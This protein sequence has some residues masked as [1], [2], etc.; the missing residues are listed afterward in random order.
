MQ[1]ETDFNPA[2]GQRDG[3]DRL[4]K[5]SM[6]G[7]VPDIRREPDGHNPLY[8]I[9][10]ARE[11]AIVDSLVTKYMRGV[12]QQAFG[13]Y[14]FTDDGAPPTTIDAPISDFAQELYTRYR[15]RGAQFMEWALQ[16]YLAQFEETMNLDLLVKNAR[17]VAEINRTSHPTIP[18]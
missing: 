5:S 12:H 16:E 18:Q 10:T 4:T 15:S 3:L 1:P 2:E 9:P 6:A 11:L 7:D 13:D 14:G 17:Q 8:F